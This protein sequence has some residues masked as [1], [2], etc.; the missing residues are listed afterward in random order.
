MIKHII[1]QMEQLK[2][3]ISQPAA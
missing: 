3:Q 2:S 1:E